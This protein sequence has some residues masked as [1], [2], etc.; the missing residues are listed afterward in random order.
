MTSNNT[1]VKS[2]NTTTASHKLQNMMS[3]LQL[4]SLDHYTFNSQIKNVKQFSLNY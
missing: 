2:H 4:Y 1:F 3:V